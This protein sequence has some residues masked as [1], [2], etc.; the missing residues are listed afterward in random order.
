MLAERFGVVVEPVDDYVALFDA[1]DTEACSYGIIAVETNLCG[2]IEP[3]YR[4]FLDRELTICA[5]I[6]YRADM[7]LAALPPLSPAGLAD[8]TEVHSHPEALAECR[9][10]LR[11]NL[12]HAQI[13]YANSSADG[14][15]RAAQAGGGAAAICAPDAAERLGLA[16]L[17]N[18]VC[19][20]PGD[21][22]RFW[23]LGKNNHLQVPATKVSLL[24]RPYDGRIAP[25][26]GVLGRFRAQYSRVDSVSLRQNLGDYALH[27]D[28]DPSD[29]V[30]G[31]V[32]ALNELAAVSELGRYPNLTQPDPAST[33]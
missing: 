5:E 31:L 11:E 10:W 12:P 30:S 23:V 6:V 1:L 7:V 20:A 13:R 2:M 14:A 25:I 18:S 19:D 4:A 27:V 22:T 3:H 26:V 16:V 29:D 9:S 33:T 8:V 24:V 32:S 21:I 15:Y 28:L 17:A